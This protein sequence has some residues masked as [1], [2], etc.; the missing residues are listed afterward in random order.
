MRA[1]PDQ[2]VDPTDATI[3]GAAAQVLGA[4]LLVIALLVVGGAYVL[5]WGR[6]PLEAAAEWPV[7]IAIAV[8]L[9]IHEVLHCVGFVLAGAP[10]SRVRIGYDWR[11]VLPFA[12]C[13]IALPCRGYRLA[14]VLPTLVLGVIPAALGVVSGHGPTALFGA[15]LIGTAAGDLLV[16]WAIRRVRADALVEDHPE[17]IGCRVLPSRDAT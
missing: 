2:R 11:R 12:A 14:V 3:S 17:A 16:L 7:F 13:S 5:R 10:R 4:I 6:E 15:F 9:V 1:A 8:G